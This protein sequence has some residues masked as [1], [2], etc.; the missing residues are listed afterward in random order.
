VTLTI[1]PAPWKF[2]QNADP[3][4]SSMQFHIL[5]FEGPDAYSRAG[6]IASRVSGLVRALADAGYETHLWFV[7]DP[8]LRGHEI[9]GNLHLHRWCQWIS[10]HHPAGV[11]DG[12][13]GKRADY[14][15]SL[16]P[17]L[18]GQVL[19]PHVQHGGQAVV[20][21]EEWHTVDAVLHLNWLLRQAQVQDHV[22][23]LWNANNTFS[24]H[25]IDWRQL[26]EAATITTVSR[27][28]K[29]LMQGV[30]VNALVIPNGLAT[31]ALISPERRAMAAFRGR[32]R[33]RTVLC[34]VARWDPDKRWLLAIEIVAALKRQ[35]WRPLLIARG[36]VEAHGHEVLAAATSGGLR[37][38]ERELPEPGVQG[39][40]QA[41]EGLRDYDIVNLSSPL[42]A[43]AQRVL[44]QGAAAVLANSG[45]EPYGLVGLETMAVGGVACTGCSGEDYAVPG[46]NALV[47]ETTDPGEFVGLFAA[48]RANPALERAI[49]RAGCATAKHYI[50]PQII[51]RILL[52]R[53]SLFA[54]QATL[55]SGDQ[56][57]GAQTYTPGQGRRH[58]RARDVLEWV[59]QGADTL[60][61]P[62]VEPD[63]AHV[64]VTRSKRRRRFDDEARVKLLVG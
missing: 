11:Y 63:P 20:L 60:A 6:G 3:E 26:A 29:H 2:P 24:F 1:D 33:H 46:Y 8:A 15:A 32:L 50:W 37:V 25:R 53:L 27:Y 44:F 9:Q 35:G 51:Q 19:L 58:P 47:L 38:V 59:T 28:M 23:V 5:S 49:R 55:V 61:L 57:E 56:A 40:M 62:Q 41:M 52:P 39:L 4:D 43:D 48:L 31:E 34:K 13:E 14:V 18:L 36:G 12:E 21:A 16:P 17:Y 54:P 45:H 22:T 7:G 42:R 10:Q 64:T 30:G